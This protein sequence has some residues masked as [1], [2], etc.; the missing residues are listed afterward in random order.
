MEAPAYAQGN[1]SQTDKLPNFPTLQGAQEAE[2]SANAAV[3]AVI[4]SQ[5][6]EDEQPGP[7]RPQEQE[8]GSQVSSLNGQKHRS[9]QSPA[10]DIGVV[11]SLPASE[12]R[13][14][15]FTQEAAEPLEANQAGLETSRHTAGNEE[16]L[17]I[18]LE[19][20]AGLQKRTQGGLM[21][22]PAA[23]AGSQVPENSTAQAAKLET[24][25]ETGAELQK[26]DQGEPVQHSAAKVEIEAS[27]VLPVQRKESEAIPEDGAEL[28][29]AS[30]RPKS[31]A[32]EADCYKSEVSTAQ[33]RAPIEDGNFMH[34]GGTGT[35]ACLLGGC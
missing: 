17:G 10:P 27:E 24:A 25:V 3:S 23:E 9:I 18:T 2:N 33:I 34:G 16:E 1:S 15:A 32:I 31:L 26:A 19:V 13:P 5:L 11:Q 21:K 29:E 30:Q 12:K 6:G 20:E 28:Q 22:R 7:S 4:A 14:S 8:L 35:N